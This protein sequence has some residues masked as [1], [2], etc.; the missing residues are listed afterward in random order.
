MKLDPIGKLVTTVHV[1]DVI[2]LFATSDARYIVNQVA[3]DFESHDLGGQ[4][5][6]MIRLYP[7]FPD[8]A[9]YP[10]NRWTFG[11]RMDMSTITITDKPVISRTDHYTRVYVHGHYDVTKEMTLI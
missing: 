1:G 10:D 9:R 11:G 2:S 8:L 7:D 4:L 3:T 6:E 5:V